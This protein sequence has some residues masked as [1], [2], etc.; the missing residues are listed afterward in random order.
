[1]SMHQK[2][3][4]KMEKS[5][6]VI[7]DKIPCTIVEGLWP[8]FGAT[9]KIRKKSNFDRNQLKFSMQH[10]NVHMHQKIIIEMEKFLVAIFDK[11]LCTIVQD[12]LS[13]FGAT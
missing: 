3:I 1:M 8:N 11:I 7:F 5:L 12:I 10:K 2:K 13:N 9:L 6:L 4:I